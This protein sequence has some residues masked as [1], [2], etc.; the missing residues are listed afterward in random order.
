MRNAITPDVLFRAL[1]DF[2][3]MANDTI[4]QALMNVQTGA[5]NVSLPACGACGRDSDQAAIMV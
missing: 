1:N 5:W 4:F 2:G 3:V